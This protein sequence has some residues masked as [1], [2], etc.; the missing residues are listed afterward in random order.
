MT[1]TTSSG[2]RA[3]L[4]THLLSTENLKHPI[5]IKTAQKPNAS[6]VSSRKRGTVSSLF[7]S[8]KTT[9]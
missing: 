8:K 3:F 9:E 2:M 6:P 7:H 1:Y 5:L 4:P